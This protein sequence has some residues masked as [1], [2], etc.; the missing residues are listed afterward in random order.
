MKIK[1]LLILCICVSCFACKK[2]E[3]KYNEK[4]IVPVKPVWY[5][6][7]YLESDIYVLEE[8]NSSQGNVS[9]LI[10]G[11]E[12]AIMF[13]TGSGENQ[14]MGSNKITYK[15]EELT[16][17]PV[18]LLLSHFHFDHNQNISEFNRIIFPDL[19]FLKQNVSEDSIY[20]FSAS[21]LF[22]GDYPAEVQIDEW[23][24]VNTEIDLGN[25]TIKLLNI[26]GHTDESVAII[27]ITNKIAFLGD[28]LYN[29]A[30]FVFD[31][32]DLNAYKKSVDLLL[33]ELGSDYRL[34]GAHGVPEVNYGKLETLKDFLICI[35]S[36][37]CESESSTVWGHGVLI[38]SYKNLQIVVFQ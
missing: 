9:Y 23:Y 20:S 2:D 25:R 24:P 7:T 17:L 8:P 6:T 16:D 3:V 18:S 11:N 34:F 32:G 31:N 36:N 30:L 28:F 37:N 12:K 26:P 21:E 4:E 19:P 33:S 27:D 29:G 13:D 22:L 15:L 1:L 5:K 35:N 10:I 38:Y 14:A